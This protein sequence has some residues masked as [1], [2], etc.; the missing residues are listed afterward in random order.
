[1]SPPS[2]KVGRHVPR[3]THQIAPM[4][5]TNVTAK[6]DTFLREPN[7]CYTVVFHICSFK[8]ITVSRK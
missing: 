7:P 6:P 1:M 2:E 4:V 3:V 5:T 8:T